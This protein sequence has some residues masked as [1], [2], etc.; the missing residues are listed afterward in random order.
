MVF[1]Q[2]R[3]YWYLWFLPNHTNSSLKEWAIC[4]ITEK[5]PTWILSVRIWQNSGNVDCY[6]FLKMRTIEVRL[7]WIYKPKKKTIGVCN[8]FHFLPLMGLIVSEILN[9]QIFGQPMNESWGWVSSCSLI[10][11]SYFYILVISAP[12]QQ[13]DELSCHGSAFIQYTLLQTLLPVLRLQCAWWFGQ[14]R[15]C[16]WLQYHFFYIHFFFWGSSLST[17]LFMD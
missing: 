9:S 3:K 8:L 11:S 1:I 6:M 14:W 5:N 13:A 16:T 2:G 12:T 15:Y 4:T 10:H 7:L 17:C